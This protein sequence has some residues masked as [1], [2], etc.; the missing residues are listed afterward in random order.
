VSKKVAQSLARDQ[1]ILSNAHKCGKIARIRGTPGASYACTD[2][3]IEH[4]GISE[5]AVRR[6]LETRQ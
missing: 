4:N 5:M 6:E 1:R 3:N 2:Q